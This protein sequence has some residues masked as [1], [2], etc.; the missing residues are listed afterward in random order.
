MDDRQP[1]TDKADLK[2]QTNIVL[3]KKLINEISVPQI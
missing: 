1:W 2:R 3:K